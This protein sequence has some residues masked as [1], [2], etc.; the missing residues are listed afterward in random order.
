MLERRHKEQ[1]NF[2]LQDTVRANINAGLIKVMWLKWGNY[3]KYYERPGLMNQVTKKFQKSGVDEQ[4]T[5]QSVAVPYLC[6]LV[7]PL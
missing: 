5:Q 6:T 3:I 1:P 2:F 4:L 7:L